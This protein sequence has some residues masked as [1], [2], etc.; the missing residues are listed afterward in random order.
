MPSP[1]LTKAEII[2]LMRLH[3]EA[4]CN[5]VLAEQPFDHYQPAHQTAPDMPPHPGETAPLSSPTQL[6]ESPQPPLAEKAPVAI[7]RPAAANG[8]PGAADSASALAKAANSLD[9]LAE[10][11]A[12]FDGCALKKTA[13]NTVFSDGVAGAEVMIVGEAPGQDEDRQGKPFVGR[14]GQLLDKMLAAIGLSRATN[15]YIAN[16]VAW[17][18]PGNRTPSPDE[19]ALCR[20]FIA[21]QIE[22]AA[23][24]VLLFV[25]NSSAKTLLDTDTGITRLRG[26]W[27]DYQADGLVIPALPLLH[28]A[29]ILRRPEAKLDM[30]VDLCA[31]RQKLAGDA[32]A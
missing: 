12:A 8:G 25:G 3:V 20:P 1:Q 29:Y 27:H 16:V 7:A 23:P 28:P 5:E 11:L 19:I 21:R 24:K 2:D 14:S 18:P 4:G 15:V 22:L 26:K 31:L 30:W 13:K 6:H 17:R 32:T 10:A 9:E